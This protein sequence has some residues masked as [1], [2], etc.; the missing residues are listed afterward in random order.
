[1]YAVSFIMIMSVAGGLFQKEQPLPSEASLSAAA[2]ARNA[3][4][5]LIEQ[6]G[7]AALI[8][9][10]EGNGLYIN[11][12]FR[13]FFNVVSDDVTTLEQL[14]SGNEEALAALYRLLREAGAGR[15]V[16]EE[17]F[18]SG[19]D[20]DAL[21]DPARTSC[22]LRIEV[23]PVDQ[24]GSLCFWEVF[25]ITEEKTLSEAMSFGQQRAEDPLENLPAGVVTFDKNGD[26]LYAN[27][28]LK[29][30]VGLSDGEETAL[31][32][33]DLVDPPS[34]FDELHTDG[35]VRLTTK[36][37][38][39]PYIRIERFRATLEGHESGET[40]YLI[41]E[42]VRPQADR[43]ERPEEDD[44]TFEHIRQLN[45]FIE[46]APVGIA[47]VD[48]EGRV[49][50]SNRMMRKAVSD[51][52]LPGDPIFTGIRNEDR[53]SL[54]TL[55]S[56]AVENGENLAPIDVRMSGAKERIC[57][58]YASPVK[59]EAGRPSNVFTLYFVDSTEQKSLE[60]QFT[61]S[62]KMQA[63]GQLAGGVAHDFN[64]VLTAIIGY[65]DLLLG[66]H[67]VGDPSFA[68]INQI[69]QNANRAANLVRQLL[70]FSRKQTLVPK[71]LRLSD[72][73]AETKMLLDRLLG[74]KIELKEAHQRDLGLVKVDQGQ[75]EQVVIN[76]AVNARDAMKE[77]GTL[78]IRTYNVSE[79]EAR[80]LGHSVMPAAAY[81][82]LELQDTGCGISAENLDKIFEPFY[83][84][85]GVGEGTGL[86]LSTVYG[87]V[88]QTG[89][90]IFAD[91]DVGKGTTF[92]I[93]FQAQEGEGEVQATQKE[94]V[95]AKDLTGS[96][97]VLLVE[98]EDAVRAFASRAL[99]T[100][101]YTVIEAA[102]G[103]LGLEAVIEADGKI[104]LMISDVVMPQM[105]GPTMAKKVKEINPDI[106]IIFI[107]GYT[108]D[109]FEDE[110]DRPEDFVFLQKP[111][112][113]KE[114]A[115][116]VKEVMD[117]A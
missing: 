109:A 68:D 55:L 94:K 99:T 112:S 3:A 75:L 18:L 47:I 56:A 101:G 114:L 35:L 74:E 49:L 67:K 42:Y 7:Q 48:A 96:G 52:V 17:F 23:R 62:Q 63:V 11:P 5:D 102:N 12:A 87:I 1:V 110:L 65:C 20:L 15:R 79:D 89:G 36:S 53:D 37:G 61:Q 54:K 76:L 41:S 107:S 78:T 46:T 24:Q 81:V 14:F 31:K 19:S 39:R 116:K 30:W 40:T 51:S 73:I 115:A 57:Q 100:R 91:S 70:A 95:E 88:K 22:W 93:Y 60:L 28:F 69:K 43:R 117:G 34:A 111:F 90:F 38:P 6:S 85:K 108:E 113:L 50:N 98:D 104:D 32:N 77:G 103:E 29:E 72:A 84:T 71:V 4:F 9:G 26:V 25:D 10:S 82:C 86:G 44:R 13:D 21:G 80:A 8:T 105:D 97:T 33:S 16:S 59:S 45:D 64:N 58:V 66:Q 83:T 27:R 2:R 106:K 92:R